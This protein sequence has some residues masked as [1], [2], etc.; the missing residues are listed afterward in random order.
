[1]QNIGKI[2]FPYKIDF[3]NITLEST[4]RL[5]AMELQKRQQDKC[6]MGKTRLNPAVSRSGERLVRWLLFIF[7]GIVR[8]PTFQL[9]KPATSLIGAT[10]YKP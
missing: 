1:M 10:W 4:S 6:L 2:L 7:Q 8:F 9:F 5:T 3:I